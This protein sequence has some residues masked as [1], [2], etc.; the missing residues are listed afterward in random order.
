MDCCKA[1]VDLVT[2]LSTSRKGIFYRDVVSTN[3]AA[4]TL[5]AFHIVYDGIQD[6]GL[7]MEQ[8]V[9]SEITAGTRFIWKKGRRKV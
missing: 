3:M 8:F 7:P 2:W 1:S 6:L 5:I 9:A 4:E